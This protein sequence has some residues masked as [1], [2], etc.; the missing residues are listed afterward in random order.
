MN[1]EQELLTDKEKAQ[2]AEM[3]NSAWPILTPAQKEIYYCGLGVLEFLEKI[4]DILCIDLNRLENEDASMLLCELA[5][6]AE[7]E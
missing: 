5:F 4:C 1:K 2:I 6:I 3:F 7:E